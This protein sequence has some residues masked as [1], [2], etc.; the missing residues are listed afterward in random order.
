MHGFC[1]WDGA[2]LPPA[3]KARPPHTG[4]SLAPDGLS[5][6]K[7][8]LFRTGHFLLFAVPP[9]LSPHPCEEGRTGSFLLA[10]RKWRPGLRALL[11]AWCGN[12]FA[13]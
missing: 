1:L 13:Q 9:A 4:V 10:M 8:L 2:S 12:L 5:L 3:S 7:V 6:R 11:A